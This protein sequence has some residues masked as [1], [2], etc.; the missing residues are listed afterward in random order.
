MSTGGQ[1]FV[2]P[3]AS[4]DSRAPT[5]HNIQA[6]TPDVTQYHDPSAISTETGPLS[7]MVPNNGTRGVVI[8]RADAFGES[9]GIQHNAISP[10]IV[11]NPH[12]GN[13]VELNNT[14]PEQLA[15]A[16]ATARAPGPPPVMAQQ[17]APVAPAQVVPEMPKVAAAQPVTTG[18]VAPAVAAWGTPTAPH[19]S[20]PVRQAG[21]R[22]SQRL[23]GRSADA[24]GAVATPGGV[25]H[26]RHMVHYFLP[27]F[28]SPLQAAFHDIAWTAGGSV[29]ALVFDLRY[30]GPE[31]LLPPILDE[32][33]RIYVPEYEL[34][35]LVHSLGLQYTTG[36]A[37]HVVLVVEN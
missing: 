31:P 1:N 18:F 4:G 20:A 8:P 23:A 29:V 10:K 13:S 34:D 14:T 17:V 19:P 35:V 6:V 27:G 26:P 22:L 32:P 9:L 15:M 36:S 24:P 16:L 11:I 28:G 7:R 12:L 2:N 21:S 37:L 30:D 25:G 3:F 33:M 5:M